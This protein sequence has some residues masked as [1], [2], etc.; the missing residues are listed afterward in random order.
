M[1]RLE[2]YQKGQAEDTTCARL[3]EYCRTGWPEKRSVEPSLLQYWKA[4]SSLTV[5]KDLLLYNNRIVVPVALRKETLKRVHEGHQGIERCRMRV[6][7]SVWWPGIAS[8][9]QQMV[10]QCPVCARAASNRKEPLMPTP[11]PDYPWQV[12]GSDLFEL[13]GEQ[14]LLIVDYFLRF[15]EVIKMT[16]TTSAAIITALKSIFSRYGIPEVLRSDNGS[17]YASRE[18]VTF[19]ES[20][21][22]RHTTSSPR[23]AQSNGQAERTVKTVKKLL[24]SSNDC[25]MALLSYRATPFP[26]VTSVLPSF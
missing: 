4:R 24:K 16:T 23:Y 15:P 13:K 2:T 7:S 17:Q 1:Q 11:L 10:E 21:G 5:H 25:Y 14:Y 9:I 12:V 18:F 22:F 20:Y 3:L 19:A 6:K 26:G 8:Q